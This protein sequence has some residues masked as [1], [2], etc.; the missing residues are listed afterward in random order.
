MS[1]ATVSSALAHH[2]IR[3]FVLTL[4]TLAAT[5]GL[6]IL[7]P[8]IGIGLLLWASLLSLAVFG[9]EALRPH[10]IRRPRV[11]PVS[12]GVEVDQVGDVV[13]LVVTHPRESSDPG[14]Y[15]ADVVDISG[16]E[17]VMGLPLPWHVK[18]RDSTVARL[19]ILPG[20]EGVLEIAKLRQDAG[21]QLLWGHRH[22]AAYLFHS[23]GEDH[24]VDAP[25]GARNWGEIG[26]PLVAI[27]LSRLA[28]GYSAVIGVRLGFQRAPALESVPEDGLL[29]SGVRGQMRHDQE[30]DQ[31]AQ[32]SRARL[33][34]L[35]QQRL[36]RL[37]A[38]ATELDVLTRAAQWSIEAPQI[39][40]EYTYPIVD[41]G[42]NLT[43]RFNEELKGVG[44]R[45]DGQRETLEHVARIHRELLIEARTWDWGRDGERTTQRALMK[46]I[47]RRRPAP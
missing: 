35:V 37:V 42:G 26:A 36:G 14:D 21:Q 47:E 25:L 12:P 13:R 31:Q 3:G 20:Q 7:T 29:S 5:A 16:V 9:W 23:P 32:Q 22:E 34:A 33:Y 1:D 24:H 41:E 45:A 11:H 15:E 19:Q 44:V 39:Y 2:P 8:L 46:E 17:T 28:P 30:R 10:L 43:L 4:I 6:G 40:R 27:R 18:W 38:D